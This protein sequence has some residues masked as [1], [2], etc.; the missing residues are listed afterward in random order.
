MVKW[1]VMLWLQTGCVLAK[2]KSWALK[3]KYSKDMSKI[4]KELEIA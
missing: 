4:V 2:L 1:D 3:G